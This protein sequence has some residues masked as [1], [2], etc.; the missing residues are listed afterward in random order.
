M[1]IF[2]SLAFLASYPPLDRKSDNSLWIWEVPA[3][4][5]NWGV[6]EKIICSF[7]PLTWVQWA[8][9][10]KP[11]LG[12][13]RQLYNLSPARLLIFY[14]LKW[15]GALFV[16]SDKEMPIKRVR[17][18]PV[19]NADGV[20]LLSPRREKHVRTCRRSPIFWGSQRRD[21]KLLIDGCQKKTKLSV[22]TSDRISQSAVM[23]RG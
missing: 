22:R 16:K 14:E 11:T 6:E 1:F 18:N 8:P 13:T 2:L 20:N 4:R 12:L 3:E 7:S 5:S 23:M 10:R 21:T 17:Y 15:N 19:W 9:L